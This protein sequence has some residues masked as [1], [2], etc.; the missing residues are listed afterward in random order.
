MYVQRNKSIGKNGKVYR[1]V[2]LCHKYREAGKIKT[3]VLANLSHLPEKTVL[4][5]G[6]SLLTIFSYLIIREMESKIYPFLKQWNKQN[7]KQLSF[8]DIMEELK[9]IKLV[10]LKVGRNVKSV[11]FTV[12]NTIQEQVLNFF[13]LKKLVIDSFL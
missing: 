10:T 5:I 12:L 6:N 1:S 9:D 13:G 7:N 2:L 3:K 8:N 11:Q 4:L